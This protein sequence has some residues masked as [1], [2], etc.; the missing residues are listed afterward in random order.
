MP[1]PTDPGPTLTALSAEPG[2]ASHDGLKLRAGWAAALDRSDQ[3]ETAP[4]TDGRAL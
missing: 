2:T 3:S 1:L 4:T